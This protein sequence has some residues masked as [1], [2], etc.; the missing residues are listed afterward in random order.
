MLYLYLVHTEYGS[1][2]LVSKLDDV[3][4]AYVKAGCRHLTVDLETRVLRR[5]QL[6]AQVDVKGQSS[7]VPCGR[8][9]EWWD[10]TAF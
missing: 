1:N 3:V 6:R 8:Y 4:A 2:P 9:V 5:K 10:C 7:N